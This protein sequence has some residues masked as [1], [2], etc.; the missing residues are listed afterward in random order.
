MRVVEPVVGRDLLRQRDQFIRGAEAPR[1]VLRASAESP[2]AVVHPGADQ[3]RH[4]QDLVGRRGAFVVVPHDH[5][6]HGPVPD[7]R[8]HVRRDSGFTVRIHLGRDRPDRVAAVGAEDRG[9]D[10]LHDQVVRAPPLDVLRSEDAVG[11]GVHVDEAGH[12]VLPGSVDD[13]R[14]AGVRQPPDGDDLVAVDAHV[15]GERGAARPVEDHS[16]PD[17]EVELLGGCGG[18]RG[19]GGRGGEERGRE[20]DSAHDVYH[21]TGAG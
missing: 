1:P 21:R 17:E 11:V 20:S 3:F 19:E 7:H 18:G 6:S 2:G 15:R 13:A 16:A 5:A 9:R 14:G 4:P 10:S 12:D 8:H